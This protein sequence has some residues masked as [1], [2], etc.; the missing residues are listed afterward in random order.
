[1]QRLNFDIFNQANA[2]GTISGLMPDSGNFETGQFIYTPNVNYN[3]AGQ[4]TI[5]FTVRDDGSAGSPFP[6]TSLP[7]TLTL[8]VASVNDPPTGRDQVG[9]AAVTTPEDTAVTITLIGDDDGNTTTSEGQNLTFTIANFPA[10]GT[11]K[12][13]VDVDGSLTGVIGR[14]TSANGMVTYQPNLNFNNNANSPVGPDSFTFN[15]TDDGTPSETSVTP[16]TVAINVTPVNDSP[17]PQVVQATTTTSTICQPLPGVLMLGADLTQNVD[18]CEDHVTTL[19]LGGST[20]DDESAQTMTFTLVNG[21]SQGSLGTLTATSS[22]TATVVYTPPLGFNGTTTFVVRATDN[23]QT[24]GVPNSL[25]DELTVTI[26]VQSVNAV[27]V[28][29]NQSVTTLEDNAKAIAL[30]ADDGDPG[31]VQTLRYFVLPGADNIL[32][33]TANG[34]LSGINPSTG[35][36]TGQLIYTPDLNFNGMDSL[37]FQVQDDGLAG[38]PPNRFSV[39]PGTV[40]ITVTSVND[41]PFANGQS[42]VTNE[43]TTI[44]I[45]LTGDDGDPN[46]TQTL[47][48]VIAVPPAR[49]TLDQTNIGSGIVRYTPSA[50]FNGTDTFTFRVGDNGTNPANLF[51]AIATVT[52]TVNPLNDAP[53]FTIGQPLT[54]LEDSGSQTVIAWTSGIRP[55]PTTANDEA[56]QIVSFT[57]T[58][59]NSSLFLAS[60]QPSVSSSGTLTFTPAPNAVGQAVLTVVAKDTGSGVSPHVNTSTPQTVT[61]TVSPVN[62][63]PQFI[64]GSNQSTNEDSGLQIVNA[65]ATNIAPGPVQAIDESNQGLEF[66]V[67]FVTTG[68]LAFEPGFEPRISTMTGTFGQLSYRPKANTNGTATVT[69]TLRDNGDA[70][71]PNVNLSSTETFSITVNP[72]NDAPEFT[73]GADASVSEDAGL[74][75]IVDWATNVRPG[76]AAATDENSQALTFVAS[77]IGF[78][79]GLTFTTAPFIEPLTGDL[80]FQTSP[81]KWGTATVTVRLRDTGAGTAPHSNESAIHTLTISVASVNDPPEFTLGANQ[82]LDEDAAAQTLFGFVTSI[83]PGPA[84]AN[85]EAG[86]AVNFVTTNDNNSLFAVQ[87]AI[88]AIGT[89]TYSPAANKN[90][91]AVVT[92]DAQ[93]GGPGTAPDVNSAMKTFTITLNAVNDAPTLTVPGAQTVAEDVAKGLGGIVAADLDVLEGTGRVQVAFRATNG[94]LNLNTNIPGGVLA[95]QVTDNGSSTVSVL[96]PLAQINTTL[97]HLNSQSEADGLTYAGKADFNGQDQLVITVDDLGNTGKPGVLTVTRTVAITVT[98]V[99]DPPVLANPVADITVDEDAPVTIVEL[100]PQVF[101]DPDVLTNSDRLTI[102]VVGNSNPVVVSTAVNGTALAITPVADA[103]GETLITIEASDTSGEFVQDTFRFTVLSVNDAPT[104]VNDSFTVPG[105]AATVL[106]VLA[107]DSDKDSVINPATLAI[108]S[109]PSGGSVAVNGNGTITFTPNVGF[110]GPTTFRYSVSDTQ[111]ATSQPATVTVTVNEPPLA[112]ADAATTKQGIPVLISVLAND[113]DSDGT[114]VNTSVA[115][116]QQ[117]ANGAVAVSSTGVVTYTPDSAF[118]GTDTFKYTVRDNVGG[119]SAPGTVTVTVVPFRPWQN[120]ADQVA[121]AAPGNLDVSADGFVS[122]I[123]VLLITNRINRQGTGPLPPPTSSNSPP[124]F[125]DVNGD[126]QSTPIDALLIINFLNGA[127]STQA[128]GESFVTQTDVLGATQAAGAAAALV[129]EFTP[130]YRQSRYSAASEMPPALHD[131]LVAPWSM[132]NRFAPDSLVESR[133]DGYRDKIHSSPEEAFRVSLELDDL[134][135][136]LAWNRASD[137][138]PRSHDQLADAALTDLLEQDLLSGDN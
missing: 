44:A 51:S 16:A 5:V 98:P 84:S 113:T 50:D 131:E 136:D 92:V 95:S 110:Q 126:G 36:V 96:A 125:Y 26:T 123:D 107:N 31:V 87:P 65:W 55:G 49:G 56:G 66:L 53:Q 18:T 89:L 99:N 47:S 3:G 27:P 9:A 33:R 105:S 73:A 41:P 106:A 60:G 86:Q 118:S 137:D 20:G 91:V 100:F 57:T 120:P 78:T 134:L 117:P 114:I 102:R 68:N 48:Y 132:A 77:T 127:G 43:D 94:T 67:N 112:N 2:N 23:G 22:T 135:T 7:F 109:A 128:E 138:E 116:S 11:F 32:V 115:I 70:A 14:V 82:Q 90:G 46:E 85:D 17:L 83:R 29:N 119:V 103:S 39:V 93:D 64:K 6:Q 111:G 35:E 10:H 59:N 79:G 122:A 81:N 58:N 15:V 8:N 38:N 129:T 124:P 21:P 30:T 133:S 104:A 25:S 75:R 1:N 121:N 130:G 52:V 28:A 19:T 88:S 13:G 45:T 101:N 42:V 12:S 74:V 4:A 24:N 62:D 80:V 108:V 71:P 63:A 54:V 40:A 97:A 69:V 72:I 76:P 34:T 61:L 37:T